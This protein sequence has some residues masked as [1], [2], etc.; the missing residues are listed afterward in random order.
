MAREK[1][2]KR[3]RKPLVLLNGEI[4]SP[5]MD[6][7]GR[8]ETG[9]L[10]GRLQE[11]E[12]L[13]PPASRPMPSIGP[14]CYELR[15]RDRR[16]NWRIFYRIDPDAVVVADVV[17]KKTEATLRRVIDSCRAR[18]ARYDKDQKAGY[19]VCDIDEFLGLSP[20]EVK[21]TDLK[22]DL[23][24]VIR[25]RREEAGLTQSQ[26]AKKVGS[27]QPRI[28]RIENGVEATL[29]LMLICHFAL[30][31]TLADLADGDAGDDAPAEKDSPAARVRAGYA[32]RR[33]ASVPIAAAKKKKTVPGV[34]ARK[35][36]APSVA[37]RKAKAKP[38]TAEAAGP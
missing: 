32:R 3:K 1:R 25:G 18:F 38:S 8:R 9:R 37:A 36:T 17:S 20:E 28:A 22:V 14:R 2:S 24:R 21:L 11:G 15:V 34:T 7:Q 13:V 5:P 29:D 10:L 4:K 30:G 33:K 12:S 23:A 26:L 16:G 6:E 27:S 31:G 35:R 19:N